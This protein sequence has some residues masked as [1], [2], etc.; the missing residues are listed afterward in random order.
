MPN[1][2]K[3]EGCVFISGWRFFYFG[4]GFVVLG[5]LIGVDGD[6]TAECSEKAQRFTEPVRLKIELTRIST[7]RDEFQECCIG[8]RDE[9]KNQ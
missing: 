1:P 9:A 5:W 8:D 3:M 2:T 6:L 7:D 4:V